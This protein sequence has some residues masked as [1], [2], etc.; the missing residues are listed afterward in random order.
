MNTLDNSAHNLAGLYVRLSEEDRNKLCKE[1]DSE[2]IRNQ[3]LLL[4][5]YAIE[6]GWQI[7][8]IYC[9]DDWSG[10]DSKR[11][12]FNQMI[13]DCESGKINIV[14][15]KT[16]SRFT[17]DAELVEKYIHNKFLEWD[18]R[19]VSILDHSDTSVRGN[20]KARQING[21]INEW[22]CED[23]SEN[24]REVF[25]AK[26]RNGEY[27]ASF[28]PYG[29][30]KE[31]KNIVVDEYA[32]NVVRKIFNLYLQGYGT[33]R[34]ARILYEEGYDKPS[35]YK[36][37]V[38]KLRWYSPNQKDVELWGHT[39]INRILRNEVYIGTM[40]QS[41]E[42]TLSYKNSKR[43][44]KKRNDWII[45]ENYHEPIISKETFYAVQRLLDGKRQSGKHKGVSHI[46]AGKIHCSCCGATMLL[47]G[48]YT[49]TKYGN[50]LVHKV[51]KCKNYSL[52]NGKLCAYSN[53]IFYDDVCDAVNRELMAIVSD[54]LKDS[55]NEERV[56]K[57]LQES[58][59]SND[60]CECFEREADDAKRKIEKRINA[61][62]QLYLDKTSNVLNEAQYNILFSKFQD[63]IYVLQEKLETLND[64]IRE[65]NIQKENK[66]NVAELVKNFGKYGKLNHEVCA[67]YIDDVLIGTDAAGNRTI[68][69][70]WNIGA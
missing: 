69:I 51:F 32:A 30:V 34:I 65:R 45:F 57:S 60:E 54:F 11:P 48:S 14:L 4:T 10:M 27:L 66:F 63:E 56:I 58:E 8:K 42:T 49:R 29:Y 40:C 13:K 5:E 12:Q 6:Q 39:T 16:Q 61:M 50:R 23:L 15:C 55:Q 20:K 36:Q 41:K 21:L 19:F 70:K 44:Q 9:D 24:I 68:E 46:M 26:M 43:I 53:K 3:K 22:Y 52:S 33:H 67:K 31:G 62:S 38:Q 35:V 18:I 17:R 47:N 7:Y 37:K 25:Q 2:S 1:D 59:N 28:A 64:R